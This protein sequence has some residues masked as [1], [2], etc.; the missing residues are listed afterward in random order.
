LA[1][2]VVDIAVVVA[3]AAMLV[4]AVTA[5]VVSVLLALPVVMVLGAA[6]VAGQAPLPE[7]VAV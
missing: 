3:Q 7:E 1:V 2:D 4:L 5:Q 6:A